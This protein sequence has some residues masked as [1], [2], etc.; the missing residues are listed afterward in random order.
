M[1]GRIDG[2][3]HRRVNSQIE[4]IVRKTDGQR[5]LQTESSILILQE[6]DEGTGLPHTEDRHDRPTSIL[7]RIDTFED[8]YN[9]YIDLFHSLH[10]TF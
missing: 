9:R 1:Y 2:H 7:R 4:K 3:K 6:L 10:I 8:N 5:D